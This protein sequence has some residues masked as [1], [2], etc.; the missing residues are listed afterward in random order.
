MTSYDELGKTVFEGF[1]TVPTQGK[2]I[3]TISYTLPF[4]LSS[5]S[6][7]PVLIQKQPGTDG[8]TY[9]TFVNDKEKDTFQ[10][11][12]DKEFRVKK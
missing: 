7:L 2:A 9:T 1:V 5:G 8:N 3:F 11:F 10:L 6:D 4:K 12:A